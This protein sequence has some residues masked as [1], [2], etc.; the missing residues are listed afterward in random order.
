MKKLFF[1]KIADVI[2]RVRAFSDSSAKNF[3]K[4]IHNKTILELGS[5]RM[6]EGKYP[7]S[8]RHFF[9]E[10][11]TFVMSDVNEK[12]GHRVVDVTKMN[13]KNEFDVVLCM[14]VLEH[15]FD[16]SSAVKNV[17]SALKSGG[18][19]FF[20]VPGFFPLHDEPAD[21]W[22]FTEH[23]LKILFKDF[24]NVKIKHA[25]IREYPFAYAIEAEK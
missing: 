15:V 7:Y 21:Y 24:R 3:A 17:H 2:F 19:A 16:F 23:S 10:S 25:G 18:K 22:R 20:F 9:D 13:Y 8:A 11:N 1:K 12:Y 6:E 5:G 4:G 14:S